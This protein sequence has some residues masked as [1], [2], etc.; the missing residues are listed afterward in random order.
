MVIISFNVMLDH[1]HTCVFFFFF[2][3]FLNDF[4]G[5]FN[6]FIR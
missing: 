4:L 2:F 5:T 6:A 3:F 1:P